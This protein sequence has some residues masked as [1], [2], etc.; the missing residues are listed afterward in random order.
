VAQIYRQT[1][2]PE[3]LGATFIC[4]RDQ[5]ANEPTTICKGWWDRFALDDPLLVTAVS[6][7]VVNWLDPD[8]VN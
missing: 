7:D 2:G 1:T 6:M 5:S 8:S 4:H 3:H